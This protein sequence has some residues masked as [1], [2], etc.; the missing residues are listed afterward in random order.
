MLAMKNAE[1]ESNIRLSVM[2]AMSSMAM[3]VAALALLNLH[4]H[5]LEGRPFKNQPV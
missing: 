4:G 1:T 5:V 2:M 3:D